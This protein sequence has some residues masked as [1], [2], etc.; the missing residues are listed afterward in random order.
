MEKANEYLAVD[1][2]KRLERYIKMNDIVGITNLM[3][4]FAAYNRV[5]QIDRLI[6]RLEELKK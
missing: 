1:K 3:D 4:E 5:I 2:R 6:S